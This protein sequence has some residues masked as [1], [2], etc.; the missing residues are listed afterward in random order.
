MRVAAKLAPL[1]DRNSVWRRYREIRAD[2]ERLAAPLATEDY[3]VQSMPDTSPAKW[4]LAHVSWFFENFIVAPYARDYTPF[5]GVR[6]GVEAKEVKFPNELLV[7]MN[8]RNRA[9]FDVYRLHLD[10]G[11]LV[12]DQ[13]LNPYPGIPATLS[14]VTGDID[15][16]LGG[17]FAAQGAALAKLHERGALSQNL[18][19]RHTAMDAATIKGVVDRLTARGLTIGKPDPTDARRLRIAL[20]DEGRSV[21]KRAISVALA[22]TEETL[23]PLSASERKSL[24]RLLDKIK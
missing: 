16:E 8:A 18:L 9:V 2:T 17:G 23:K 10:T 1:P 6:A 3:V 12:L 21:V 15:A 19:G 14:I 13:F 4:H 11:A 5:Q 20:T 22:I 24:M 7:T